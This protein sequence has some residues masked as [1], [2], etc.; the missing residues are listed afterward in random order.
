MANT[1][2]ATSPPTLP[3]MVFL[4]LMCGESLCLPQAMP[5]KRAKQSFI[6]GTRKSNTNKSVSGMPAPANVRSNSSM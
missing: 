1:T 6:E 3:S 5:V 2:A 4:G